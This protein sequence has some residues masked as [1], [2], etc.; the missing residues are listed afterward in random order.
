MNQEYHEQCAFPDEKSGLTEIIKWFFVFISC[1]V[2]SLSL[3]LIIFLSVNNEW[4]VAKYYSNSTLDFFL[5]TFPFFYLLPV[6]SC[7]FIAILVFK[8]TKTG[9]A[10]SFYKVS[11]FI[12]F[13]IVLFSL[14]FFYTG[15][16]KL[17]DSYAQNFSFYEYSNKNRLELWQNPE[18][19][20]LSGEI[21]IITDLNDFLLVDFKNKVWII[22]SASPKIDD[23]SI[24][25]TGKKIKLIGRTMI[26]KIVS[27]QIFG[28]KSAQP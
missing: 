23:K 6:F 13:S 10:L 25:K 15:L 22:K 16:A 3:S 24:I 28:L 5:T 18:F 21:G 7:L 9:E 19:G 4:S 1:L 11:I 14:I 12:S 8:F 17:T 27:S 2:S 26:R 20:L